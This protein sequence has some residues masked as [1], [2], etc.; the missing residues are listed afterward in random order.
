MFKSY[1]KG[2]LNMFNIEVV[3]VRF[4]LYLTCN[5]NGQVVMVDLHFTF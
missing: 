2:G 1:L 3:E 4:K 5:T